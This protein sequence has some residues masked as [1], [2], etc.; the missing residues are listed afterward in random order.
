MKKA[1]IIG[2]LTVCT[3]LSAGLCACS[4]ENT[5]G[6]N[7]TLQEQTP[8]QGKNEFKGIVDFPEDGVNIR[9]APHFHHKNGGDDKIPDLRPLLRMPKLKK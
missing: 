3:A 4:G 6:G 8:E 1:I 2:I 7:D 9:P 5:D